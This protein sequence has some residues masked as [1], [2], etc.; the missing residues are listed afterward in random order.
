MCGIIAYTGCKKAKP[1]LLDGLKMLEY[2]GYDSA[3]I[4]VI[5]NGRIESKRVVGRV[6]NLARACRGILENSDCG[7]AHTR[8]ATHGKV[9]ETNAHPHFD[10]AD[11]IAVVHNGIIENYAELKK[12]LENEGHKF[13]SETDTEVLAHLVEKFSHEGAENAII[14]AL[15]LVEGAYAIALMHK[16][17]P[18]KI[19]A[20]RKSSPLV[21]GVGKN[22]FFVASDS[23]AIIPYTNKVIFLKD[24]EVA[25]ITPK[26]YTIKNLDKT[27]VNEQITDLKLKIEEVHKGGFQNFM[28][29]EIFEQPKSIKNAFR[30]R[31]LMKEGTAK[32]GG[33]NID[34]EK[35]KKINRII[36]VGCG[37]SYHACLYGKYLLG[38]LMEIPTQAEYASEFRYTK[39]ALDENTLLI[40]LS[41]S[42]ET[43][44]VIAALEKAKRQKANTLGLINV[45][46]STIAREVDGVIYLHAGQEIAVASTK[47]FTSHMVEI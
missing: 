22:E 19:F 2:R 24:E 44:D 32:F 6:N 21:I 26:G 11:N 12:M 34:E 28:L 42:G 30:G 46:G 31:I 3:G 39:Q 15:K 27:Q 8:W 45:V 43:A 7:I 33:M 9:N 23:L 41:Q 25:I 35:L 36:L 10:C 13:R 40:F 29:K 37:T 38:D 18:G 4:A 47:T 1:I 14:R 5:E 20:A 17:E 16:E